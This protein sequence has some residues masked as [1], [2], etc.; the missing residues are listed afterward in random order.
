MEFLRYGVKL[1]SQQLISIPTASTM[2][3]LALIRQPTSLNLGELA[4]RA[5]LPLIAINLFLLA[6]PLSYQ[7]PR[8]SRAINLVF[9]VLIYLTYSTLLN[10][11]QAWIVQK[12]ISFPV[13][14]SFLHVI[15]AFVVVAL[16]WL[17]IR[18]RP[19]FS[20]GGLQRL[21]KKGT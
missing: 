7:N 5:G 21:A 19:L 15:V 18:N 10:V 6:I 1:E 16:F 12:R 20:V 3:T 17:R 4:W 13:G 8:R 9:A 2:S 11:A 14:L